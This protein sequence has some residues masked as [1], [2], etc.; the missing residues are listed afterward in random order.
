M[1]IRKLKFKS[2][3]YLRI[4]IGNRI[5]NAN[6]SNYTLISWKIPIPFLYF[7]ETTCQ[8]KYVCRKIQ[9]YSRHCSSKTSRT[10]YASR[11]SWIIV[12]FLQRTLKEKLSIFLINTLLLY[13]PLL[14]LTDRRN[15]WQRN[16]YT[17]CTWAGGIFFPVVL[18]CQFFVLAGNRFWF[19]I[20]TYV[21]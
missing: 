10:F 13:I 20:L 11:N 7:R 14:A 4:N 1:Q 21:T 18:L 2:E 19:Y 16:D 15:D 17:C 9:P 3:Y 8:S 5:K 12:V 6:T